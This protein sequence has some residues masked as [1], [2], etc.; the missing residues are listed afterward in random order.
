MQRLFDT[1][2]QHFQASN[3]DACRLFHGR[4]HCYEGLTFVNVDLLPPAI[5]IT[6]YEPAE[7]PWLDQ[8]VAFCASLEGVQGVWV[9]SRFES[10]SPCHLRAGEMAPVF[11]VHEQGLQYRIE[12]GKSQNSGL[13]LDMANGRHW[14][15]ENAKG[16]RVL[17]L[18][19]YTCAFSVAAMAGGARKVVNLDMSKGAITRGRINHELNQLD[20][21]AVQFLSY[22]LFRSW[23]RLKKLGPFDLV[24]IDPPSFQ[25]GSFE[26]GKDYLRVLRR[27]PEMLIPGGQ[28]LA[29]LNDPAKESQFLFALMEEACLDCTFLGRLPNPNNFEEADSEKGLKVLRFAYR[30]QESGVG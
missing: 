4:G 9:Q 22:D 12:L 19:A 14:V 21:R 8:L 1:V 6:L 26:A 5:L 13:F 15:R 3:F 11:D 30:L 18:F 7:P 24:I 17:N 27:L 20:L 10:G 16:L 28:V 29:C 25:R 23:G 2:R